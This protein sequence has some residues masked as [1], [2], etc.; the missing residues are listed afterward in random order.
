MNN[1]FAQF[2]P[3]LRFYRAAEEYGCGGAAG[4][5]LSDAVVGTWL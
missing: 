2:W 4:S 3:I 5:A 1:M